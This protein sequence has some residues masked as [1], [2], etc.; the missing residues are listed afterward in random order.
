MEKYY[1]IDNISKQQQGPVA[2]DDLPSRNIL[3]ET[4]VWKSGMPNWVRAD[5]VE[6][7]AFLFD[8]RAAKPQPDKKERPSLEKK[9][10]GSPSG[11]QGTAATK[12]TDTPPVPKNWLL[13]SILLSILCCSPV[14]VVGIIY[15]SRV[16]SLYYSKNYDKAVNTSMK[17]RNWALGGMFFIPALY[18]L[19]YI[20]MRLASIPFSLPM[21]F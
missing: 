7:L 2:L 13:E 5:S 12:D 4:M 10:Q 8:K 20:F 9:Y 14:S 16:E 19:F 21:I 18:S 11:N 17:A 3:P 15:A 6:E 1:Y